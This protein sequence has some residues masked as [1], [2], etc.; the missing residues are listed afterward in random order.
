MI[1]IYVLVIW[2]YN[3]V[4]VNQDYRVSPNI[5]LLF[6]GLAG[7]IMMREETKNFQGIIPIQTF[8]LQTL[9]LII[10]FVITNMA[11]SP[12]AKYFGKHIWIIEFQQAFGFS[13]SLMLLA[14]LCFYLQ[15]RLI[16]GTP[17]E[18]VHYWVF[19]P[20]SI[21]LIFYDF[22]LKDLIWT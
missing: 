14:D 19:G 22:V 16:K 21:F 5:G 6:A 15:Y 3:K 1:T 18:F 13:Y 8:L 7:V 2:I 9:N 12:L 4:K 17:D 20:L 11:I 10:T